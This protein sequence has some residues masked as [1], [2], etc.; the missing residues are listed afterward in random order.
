MAL[1]AAPFTVAT[2]APVLVR[3]ETEPPA[4]ICSARTLTAPLAVVVAVSEPST[5]TVG[6]VA[7]APIFRPV[8]LAW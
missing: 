8:E 5:R 6:A 7:P 1:P 4:S 3:V 2:T